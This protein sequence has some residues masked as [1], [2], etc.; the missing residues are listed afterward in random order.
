[1][2]ERPGG[3]GVPPPSHSPSFHIFLSNLEACNPKACKIGEREGSSTLTRHYYTKRNLSLQTLGLA[4]QKTSC[5]G[6]DRRMCSGQR[7]SPVVPSAHPRPQAFS[8]HRSMSRRQGALF[9]PSLGV[10]PRE[11][12]LLPKKTIVSLT[13]AK[14]LQQRGQEAPLGIQ[15]L[16][17]LCPF[18]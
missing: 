9:H 1:M 10:L 18:A 8:S 5:I 15:A 3:L 4:Q 2:N 7:L 6:F 17:P 16:L 11:A 12:E 14:T 13:I